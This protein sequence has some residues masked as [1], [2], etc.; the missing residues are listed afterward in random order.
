MHKVRLPAV[1]R[2]A[3]HPCDAGNLKL[4]DFGLCSV[5][6]YR[7]QERDLLGACGSLPYIA[8]EVSST[9]REPRWAR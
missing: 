6:K 8:P 7:G 3:A 1:R 9:R 2:G 4:A 5:Y